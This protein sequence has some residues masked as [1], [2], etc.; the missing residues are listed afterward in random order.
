[1][2]LLSIEST[3]KYCLDLPLD[4]FTSLSSVFVT[5]SKGFILLSYPL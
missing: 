2:L 4:V 5:A 1:M 3:F